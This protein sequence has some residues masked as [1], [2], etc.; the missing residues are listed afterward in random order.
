MVLLM[1]AYAAIAM[2]FMLLPFVDALRP[3]DQSV[4]AWWSRAGAPMTVFAFLSQNIATRVG[5][6]LQWG[7]FGSEGLGQLRKKYLPV[8]TIGFRLAVVLTVMGTLIWGY[9]DLLVEMGKHRDA[10]V[11]GPSK[12]SQQNQS[13]S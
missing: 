4:G 2:L 12:M 9:G 1:F 7:A 10:A 8:R 5:E 3:H 6:H 11:T 13:P